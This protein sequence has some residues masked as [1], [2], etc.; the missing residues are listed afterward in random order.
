MVPTAYDAIQP[1][2]VNPDV[3]I[4]AP[5][6]FDEV[7]GKVQIKGTAAGADFDRY[8]VLVGQGIDPQAWI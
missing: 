2:Q 3:N 7:N 5:A 6:L 4:T 8:R 1:S